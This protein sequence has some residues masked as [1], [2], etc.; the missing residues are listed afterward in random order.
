[1]SDRRASL[2]ITVLNEVSGI[3][4]FLDSLARQTRVPDEVVIVDGGSKDGTVEAIKAWDAP[5]GC[6]VRILVEPGAGISR[7]RN[8]AIAGASYE[9]L[10]VTDAG[11]TLNADWAQRLLAR[12]EQP[13]EP[14]VV[15]GFFYP[16]GD[17]FVER[18]IAFAVTPRLS[19]IDPTRFL[20]SSRSVSFTKD[21]W[22]RAGRYPEWLDYCEDL[23]FDLAMLGAGKRFAFEPLAQVSWSARQSLGAFMKQYYRYARGDGKAGLWRKRHIARYSAYIVGAALVGLGTLHPAGIA[24]AGIGFLGYLTKTLRRIAGRRREFGRGWTRALLLSPVIVVA[25]DLAKMAGYPAGLLWRARHSPK[26]AT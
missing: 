4:E 18:S 15:S 1:M 3:T 14:D 17:G 20:P 23:V 7:G 13:D 5:D 11:T 10:L 6:T 24:V 22:A 2:I 21:A 25:G 9:T 19:E 16:T 26:V 12:Y 8:L